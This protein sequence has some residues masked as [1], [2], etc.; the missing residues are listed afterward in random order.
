MVTLDELATL[1]PEG[2]DFEAVGHTVTIMPTAKTRTLGMGIPDV[3]L[4]WQVLADGNT[5]GYIE[6]GQDVI[7][8]W[9]PSQLDDGVPAEVTSIDE[10][11]EFLAADP[12]K[13]QHKHNKHPHK[14]G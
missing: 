5:V 10:A 1:R 7:L 13:Q 11:V 8:A 12:P 14:K 3:P 2:I 9:K 4:D 6:K